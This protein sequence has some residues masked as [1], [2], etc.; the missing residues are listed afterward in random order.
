[1]KDFTKYFLTSIFILI[2]F[3]VKSSGDTTSDNVIG[4][5]KEIK[6]GNKRIKDYTSQVQIY[7]SGLNRWKSASLGEKIGINDTLRTFEQSTVLFEFSKAY[8][9]GSLFLNYNT[10]VRL[11]R[12]K[13]E[14][15]QQILEQGFYK[16]AELF[17]GGLIADVKNR[18]EAKTRDFGVIVGGTEFYISY[19]PNTN[20]GYVYVF[21]GTVK[22]KNNQG[23]SRLFEG[24]YAT[25]IKGKAPVITKVSSSMKAEIFRWHRSYRSVSRPWF[26]TPKFLV[27]AVAV[28]GTGVIIYMIN[29]T[30]STT[31]PNLPEPPEPPDLP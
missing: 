20:E 12:L 14:M 17:S 11:G 13:E 3:S 25:V 8:G 6:I 5:I 7:N 9:G 10:K 22:L 2:C 1:M 31:T 19:N 29:R 26:F 18:F 23:E 27:P 4:T 28:S 30:E 24:G 21:D 15:S 16:I